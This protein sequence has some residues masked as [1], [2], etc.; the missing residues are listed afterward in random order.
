MLI[1]FKQ[2]SYINMFASHYIHFIHFEII[3]ISRKLLYY[4]LTSVI[5]LL[6]ASNYSFEARRKVHDEI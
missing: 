5:T 2:L 1:N 3:L 6:L 4:I